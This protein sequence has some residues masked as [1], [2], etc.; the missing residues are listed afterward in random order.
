MKLVRK[1]IPQNINK[2]EKYRRLKEDIKMIKSQ[3][4]YAE[5][6]KLIKEGKR[7]GINEVIRQNNKNI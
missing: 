4:S 5:K 3:I 1:I 7:I 6:N 2:E